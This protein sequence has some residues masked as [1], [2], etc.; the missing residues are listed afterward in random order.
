M[1]FCGYD[2]EQQQNRGV[3]LSNVL[4]QH[5]PHSRFTALL[6]C[7]KNISDTQIRFALLGFLADKTISAAVPQRCAAFLLPDN[8]P[9]MAMTEPGKTHCHTTGLA[10]SLTNRPH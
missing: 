3:S 6:K 8:G 9:D 4:H 2:R 1:A 7:R 5:L 10:L